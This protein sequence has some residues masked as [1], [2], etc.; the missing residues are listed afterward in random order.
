MLET[1]Q[2]KKQEPSSTSQSDALTASWDKQL[3]ALDDQL[4]ASGRTV[5]VREPSDTTEFVVTFPQGRRPSAPPHDP[6][7]AGHRKKGGRVGLEDALPVLMRSERACAALRTAFGAGWTEGAVGAVN[8]GTAAV[9]LMDQ[10]QDFF[11]DQL[12]DLLNTV[13][14]GLIGYGD[15]AYPVEIK[16]YEGL[17]VAWAMG[18]DRVGYFLDVDDAKEYIYG[19]W[20]DVRADDGR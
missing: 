4:R 2:M 18:H 1:Q 6:P 8:A 19:N 11:G 14:R 20:D 7:L 15:E 13:W 12:P 3:R 17:F 16:G 10:L 5:A 9:A